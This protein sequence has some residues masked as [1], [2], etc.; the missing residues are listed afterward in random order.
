MVARDALRP[1]LRV[2]LA[3]AGAV[4]ASLLVLALA[5]LLRTSVDLAQD[6]YRSMLYVGVNAPKTLAVLALALILLVALPLSIVDAVSSARF[7]RAE[8]DLRDARPHAQ[9]APYEGPEGHG[10]AF[11][12]PEGRT[13][14]LA[15]APAEPPADPE[16]SPAGETAPA[17]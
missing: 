4:F 10:L 7:R 3:A 15:M 9:V 8:R 16:P 5:Y 2:L 12:A 11:D 6:A 13:L 1:A 14:L 17:A